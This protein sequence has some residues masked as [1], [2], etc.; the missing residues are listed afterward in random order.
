MS[1]SVVR[2]RRNTGRY[3][4]RVTRMTCYS[5]TAGGGDPDV[6]NDARPRRRPAGLSWFRTRYA[7]YLCKSNKTNK[8]HIYNEHRVSFLLK[9]YLLS[10]T[11][12]RNRVIVSKV[13]HRK[14]K[15][16]T[17]F[18]EHQKFTG[19]IYSPKKC[20]DGL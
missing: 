7:R 6:D 11:T 10:S 20:L 8:V 12:T 3:V 16:T 2:R 1:R 18:Q 13:S 5:R 15:E 4:F 14:I 19:N 17:V 9:C